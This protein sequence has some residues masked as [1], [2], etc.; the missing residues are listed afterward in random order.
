MKLARIFWM[1]TMVTTLFSCSNDFIDEAIDSTEN[2][3]KN[4]VTMVLNFDVNGAIKNRAADDY[5][6]MISNAVVTISGEAVDNQTRALTLSNI[7]GSDVKLNHLQLGKSATITVWANIDGTATGAALDLSKEYTEGLSMYGQTVVNAVVD[8]Q[9]VD[10]SLSY[11]AAKI[12]FV[13]AAEEANLKVIGVYIANAK[14]ETYVTPN[15]ESVEVES[16]GYYDGW[17]SDMGGEYKNPNGFGD[18]DFLKLENG[19]GI[20]ETAF[21]VCENTYSSQKAHTL[22]IIK[23]YYNNESIPG[24]YRISVNPTGNKITR[25]HHYTVKVTAAVGPGTDDPFN[26]TKDA[27]LTITSSLEGWYPGTPI[28]GGELE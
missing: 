19:S 1:I 28:N 2:G 25:N 8:N 5:E 9:V 16:A 24:Y 11:N 13:N 14:N 26:D 18:K 21:Y 22:I 6:T 17:G 4:E 12:S 3:D 7:D 15:L 20:N 23:G 10:I 27:N